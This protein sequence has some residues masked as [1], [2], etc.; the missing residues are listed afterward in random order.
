V[1][2]LT[3]SE[4][5]KGEKCNVSTGFGP[6]YLIN[7]NSIDP[8][9]PWS[10]HKMSEALAGALGEED[11]DKGLKRLYGAEKLAYDFAMLCPVLGR[12]I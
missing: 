7:F 10:N 11:I 6:Y 8:Q 9:S 3:A 4:L 5:A 1:D 2:Q 12:K